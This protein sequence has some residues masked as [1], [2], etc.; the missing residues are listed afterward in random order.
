MKQLALIFASVILLI[1]CNQSSK[2]AAKLQQQHA[3]DSLT[4][5]IAKQKTIDSMKAVENSNARSV[6]TTA[7]STESSNT[8]QTTDVQKKKGWSNKAKGAAI[9]AGVGAV[10]GAIIDKKHR[11]AGAVI[12]GV[13]GAGVGL[14]VGAILDHKKKKENQ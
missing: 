5:L 13:S 14:G 6:Q 3:Q 4:Q 2:N 8:T 9:G 11:G 7:Q 10:T 12:G 1:S